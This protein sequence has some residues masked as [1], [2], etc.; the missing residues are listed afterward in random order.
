MR[1]HNSSVHLPA[2]ITTR[3]ALSTVFAITAMRFGDKVAM[4]MSTAKMAGNQRQK[5][6][7]AAGRGEE[8]PTRDKEKNFYY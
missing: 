8:Q 1:Y 5:A 6:I 2:P 3:S 4:R 7:C